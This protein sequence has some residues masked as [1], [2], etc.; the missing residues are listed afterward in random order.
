MLYCST[1]VKERKEMHRRCEEA[2]GEKLRTVRQFMVSR[3]ATLAMLDFIAVTR[4]GRRAQGQEQEM[5]RKEKKREE[6][7][8][9]DV[10]RFEGDE[11]ENVEREREDREKEEEG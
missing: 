2:G 9:L 6:T 5:E 3:K 11:E 1:W 10:D 7:W 4:A 8:G